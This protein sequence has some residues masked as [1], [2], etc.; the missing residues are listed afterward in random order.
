MK[1]Y[2]KDGKVLFNEENH[3][4][5]LGE[6]QLTS[7]T[8]YINK[9]KNEFKRDIIASRVAKKNGVTKQEILD[10][11]QAKGDYARTMGTAIHKIFE[12]YHES[13]EIVTPNEYEKEIPAVKCIEDIFVSGRLEP[14]EVEYIVYNDKYAGQIDMI[15]KNPKGEHFILDWKTNNS[16]DKEAYGNKHML[17]KFHIFP[18]SN[19]YHYSLQLRIYQSL[20][21]D[22]DI[23][24]CFIV[25]I[26]VDSYKIMKTQ[27]INNLK[28]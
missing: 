7:V 24:D 17:H 26:D 23:K 10:E 15:A 16:I 2:S 8:T 13:K 4:Y 1:K 19:F 28:L 6:T 21:K 9:F 27:K 3:T 14:V 22:Y 5:F 12:D 25:H 18:D 11:W 20:C